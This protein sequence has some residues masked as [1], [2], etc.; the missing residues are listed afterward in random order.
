MKNDSAD[1][2]FVFSTEGH[3]EQSRHG[4]GRAQSNGL[5]LPGQVLQVRAQSQGRHRI[6][7]LK[8]RE[9][10]MKRLRSAI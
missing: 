2:L 3:R 7:R 8:K 10:G 6:D 9:G 4:Q 5:T 1:I